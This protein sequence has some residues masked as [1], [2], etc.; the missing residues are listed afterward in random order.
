MSSSSRA[1]PIVTALPRSTWAT[2][3]RLPVTRQ[4]TGRPAAKSSANN[5]VNCARSCARR[6][7]SVACSTPSRR[8]GT[9]RGSFGV[10]SIVV[11]PMA[12]TVRAFAVGAVE[13]HLADGPVTREQL[14][15]LVA[16][17]VVVARRIAV[18]WGVPIPRREIEAGAQPFAPA[19]VGELPHHVPCPPAPRAARHGMLGE[20]AGPEAEAVVMLGGQDQGAGAA[21]LGRAGPLTRVQLR[22]VEYR[23]VLVA[24]PPLAVGERIDAEMKEEGE[25][26]AL[27]GHLRGGRMGPDAWLDLFHHRPRQGAGGRPREIAS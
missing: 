25:L 9:V 8:G 24:V 13:P 4:S 2:A 10:R 27:P 22:R 18:D 16:V 20:P 23:R 5:E 21:G 14:G 6:A 19:G 17:E 26:V 12:P 1:S 15:E 3:V 7:T 11:T